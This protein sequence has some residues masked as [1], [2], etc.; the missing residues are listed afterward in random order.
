[1][2][3]ATLARTDTDESGIEPNELDLSIRLGSESDNGATDFTHG[4]Y[5][6]L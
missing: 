1:M 6:H 3:Q 4:H 2:Y 5:D